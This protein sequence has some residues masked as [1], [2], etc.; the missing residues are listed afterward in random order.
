MEC[1][2]FEA[3]EGCWARTSTVV[4]LTKVYWVWELMGAS[5]PGGNEREG[6]EGVKDLDGGVGGF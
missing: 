5:I 6:A 3:R 4:R 1:R 2:K